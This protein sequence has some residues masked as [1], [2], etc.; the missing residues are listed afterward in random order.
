MCVVGVFVKPIK[1]VKLHYVSKLK[2]CGMD[3]VIFLKL[4]MIFYIIFKYSIKDLT[5]TISKKVPK[6]LLSSFLFIL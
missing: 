6:I 4:N 2:I 5:D 1:S 3:D